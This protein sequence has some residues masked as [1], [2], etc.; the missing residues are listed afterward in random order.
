MFKR[1]TIRLGKIQ[2]VPV[3]VHY[4]WLFVI[5]LFIWTFGANL[6]P[7]LFPEWSESLTWGMSVVVT[8]LF[9]G[10]VFVHELAHTLVASRKGLVVKE[11][12]LYLFGGLSQLEQEPKKPGD[13]FW[14]AF[15]GPAASLILG[16][17][18][19]LLGFL[20]PWEPLAAALGIAASLSLTL[21]AFNLLPGFPLDGGRVLRAAIWAAKGDRELATR[22]ASRVGEFIA[23]GMMLLGIVFIVT[24]QWIDGF[25][26]MG[27]SAI[28]SRSSRTAR[29]RSSLETLL[30][31]HSVLEVMEDGGV[32]VPPQLTLDVLIEQYMYQGSPEFAV[33]RIDEVIGSINVNQIQQVPHATWKTSRVKDVMTE[34]GG[35]TIIA[36][37]TSL[38]QALQYLAQNNLS[39]L[40]VIQE[41]R[42]VG[43]LDRERL[44][45]MLNRLQI[46]REFPSME[47]E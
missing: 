45:R 21:G 46:T 32:A 18:F 13:D 33:G 14:V 31:G 12:T 1:G 41:T 43:T 15:A 37:E 30:E 8:V 39:G 29:A 40:P 27:L 9:V 23:M 16:G 42:L 4:S 11:I 22:W 7:G 35:G 19:M 38:W 34:L 44:L 25:W 28:L 3:T 26:L 6:F 24:G 36:P 5:I 17:V 47:N 20:L 10:S 2:G